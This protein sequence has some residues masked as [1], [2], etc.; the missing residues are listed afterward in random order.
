MSK[1]LSVRP[2]QHIMSLLFEIQKYL[3]DMNRTEII[4]LAIEK[5]I[6][7][8]E[9]WERISKKSYKIYQNLDMPEFMQ[10][11]IKKEL[12]DTIYSEILDSF[13]EQNLKRVTAP[14]LIKL[15]LISYLNSLEERSSEINILNPVKKKL[16]E[17]IEYQE[18]KPKCSYI[19]NEIVHDVYRA[20][21]DSDCKLVNGNLM[22][23]TI[24]SLWFPLKMV[25][26]CLNPSEKFYKI[27]KYRKDKNYHL[28][29]IVKNID[30]FLPTTDELVEKLCVFTGLASTRANVMILPDRKMQSRGKD[31]LD[32]MPKTL[33]ECFEDGNFS[34]YFNNDDSFVVNWIKEEKLEIFF[35]GEIK[36]ENIKPL[37]KKVCANEVCWLKEKEEIIEML[38]NFIKILKVRG[39]VVGIG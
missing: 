13:K 20:L 33:Y 18:Y 9:N 8:N 14:Y 3:P 27:D 5:S 39:D 38:D 37:I 29:R 2:N 10:I 7:R 19:G 34:K 17:W 16:K 1:I 21:N 11:K 22:A 4:N 28:K 23:D 36:K 12:Y 31:F 25:I 24:F 30:E 35:D 15:A 6:S 32:Q 26:E